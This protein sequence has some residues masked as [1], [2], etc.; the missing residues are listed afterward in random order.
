MFALAASYECTITVPA[1]RLPIKSYMAGADG[2]EEVGAGSAGV[3]LSSSRDAPPSQIFCCRISS[4]H[5]LL[6]V[7]QWW[8]VEGSGRQ[9]SLLG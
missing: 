1:S 6:A 9:D 4:R 2:V 5:T 7:D 3:S 8:R